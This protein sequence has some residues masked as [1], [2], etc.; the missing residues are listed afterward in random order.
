MCVCDGEKC[1]QMSS[2]AAA[3]AVSGPG[4]RKWTAMSQGFVEWGKE[5]ACLLCCGH[6]TRACRACRAN[7]LRARNLVLRFVGPEQRSQEWGGGEEGVRRA[8]GLGAHH[9]V[10]LTSLIW[11]R[12]SRVWLTRAAVTHWRRLLLSSLARLLHTHPSTP[13][14]ASHQQQ[15]INT[16]LSGC[17]SGASSCTTSSRTE[18]TKR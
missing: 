12:V 17:L 7:R 4:R 9:H 14:L 18:A 6:Q 1:Q 5:S 10:A 2:L 15:H 11:A 16:Q 13:F 3:A 8:A